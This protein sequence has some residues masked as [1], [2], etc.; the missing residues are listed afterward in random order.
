[1]SQQK[2]AVNSP[3]CNHNAEFRFVEKTKETTRIPRGW[4]GQALIDYVGPVVVGL[5]PYPK[6]PPKKNPCSFLISP[7]DNEEAVLHHNHCVIRA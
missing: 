2:V 7:S 5:Y 3:P 1:M 6:R 4:Q